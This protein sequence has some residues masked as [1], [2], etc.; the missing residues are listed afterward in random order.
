MCTYN[1]S[2]YLR[3]QLDSIATQ[4]RLPDELIICDDQSSD[5]TREIIESFT[6]VT[7][8]PVRL[9][10]N[11]ER[12]GSIKN[13]DKVI[14]LCSGDIIALSDQD[15]VWHPEKLKKI[16]GAFLDAPAAGLV[17]TDAEVVDEDLCYSGY[18]LWQRTF[19]Q[20]EQ[21][22]I[23]SG[24]AFKVLMTR[25]VVTGAT[26]AFRARY[27]DLVLP[28]P[29]NI[30]LIHDWWIALIIA[31]VAKIDFIDEPL[32]KYR[33]HRNQQIG[34]DL[35]VQDE[36]GH[37]G[38]R[39]ASN[40]MPA[41]AFLAQIVRLSPIYER[42]SARSDVLD[43][44]AIASRIR[45][46][47]T[48]YKTRASLPGGRLRRVPY[49]LRELLTARYH[50]YSRGLLSA[51]KDIYGRD[52]YSEWVR[53]FDSI[54]ET[55]RREI[56]HHIARFERRPIISVIMPVYNTPEK[57]LRQAIESVRKQIYP[58]W[59]L[60]IA[61]DAS[62]ASHVGEVLRHYAALDPRIKIVFRESNGHIS[63]ASNSA[64][65]LASG[66]FVAFLDHDDELHELALYC[67]AAEIDTCPD[68]ALIYS[69]EDRIDENG[70]RFHPH[71]KSDWNADLFL[72]QNFINHLGVYRIQV[73]REVCGFREG[74]E[75]SQDYDLALRVIERISPSQ[76]R[77]I[78][79]VLYHWRAVPGSTAFLISEKNYATEAAKRA[80]TSHLQRTNRDG[81]VAPAP[82]GFFR[83]VRALSTKAPR[84]CIIFFANRA[85][86]DL[87]DTL[88]KLL[89]CTDYDDYEI[90]ILPLNERTDA[91][92]GG[93]ES[94]G[95]VPIR[96]IDGGKLRQSAIALNYAAQDTEAEIVLFLDATL[97]PT[98]GGW[99][100]ELVSHA[101]RPEIGAVGAKLLNPDGKIIHAGLL[102][103][104]GKS[105]SSKVA[106]S[107]LYGLPGNHPGHVGRAHLLQNFS[108]IAGACLMIRRSVFKDMGGFDAHHLPRMFYDVDLC[109]R[110]GEKGYRVL[111][112][113]YVTLRQQY[114]NKHASS[115]P[116]GYGSA[117]RSEV[118]YMHWRWGTL[119]RQDPYYNPNF[120]LTHGDFTLAFPPRSQTSY[121]SSAGIGDRTKNA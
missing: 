96:V 89:R 37:V 42:L 115:Y 16:E 20:T 56:G 15:D 116:P 97:A 60:C 11:E 26:M 33:Q 54:G 18:R 55:E 50:R 81:R 101:L 74:Y 69:D 78:P 64:L 53:R 105:G 108:A 118:E 34:T 48:H 61:D 82:R 104:I 30:G 66:E 9:Y 13:F 28:I 95:L 65:E 67:V 5:N 113:P 68:V 80:L 114:R 49:V 57:W 27:K 32:I 72:S 120:D 75:G 59:E 12:L 6:A 17:F 92:G 8:F 98:D 90:A 3:E 14:S 4:V 79:R 100:R 77:H 40:Q 102:L 10:V 117:F 2:A 45:S 58:H 93:A 86:Q 23:K 84:V 38:L 83:I 22:L 7:P 1:G 52:Q 41:T 85:G 39:A 21:K 71:F 51:A 109:L 24:Q 29:D 46:Q 35:P 63:A 36:I 70:R 47:I 121:F 91:P 87:N 76:I 99:L 94:S 112:T 111:Y 107:A 103:G 119:L 25:N 19:D 110:L 44:G 31:A 43:G 73:V 88:Q 62:T 106:G